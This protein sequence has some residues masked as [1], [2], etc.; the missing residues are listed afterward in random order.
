[1][2]NAVITRPKAIE[3]G[4][5]RYFTGEPCPHG[6][7]VERYTSNYKCVTCA[8]EHAKLPRSKAQMKARHKKLKH[9]MWAKQKKYMQENPEYREHRLAYM[10]N[11]YRENQEYAYAKSREYVI[12][13]RA[14]DNQ[15]KKN[16]AE[17]NKDHVAANWKRRSAYIR[18]ATPSWSDFSRIKKFYAERIRLTE[19]TGQDYHVDHYYPIVS[20]VVCGL[21]VPENLQVITAVE[22]LAKSNKMPEE[23]YGIG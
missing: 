2:E 20:D 17:R 15:Y 21:H 5:P 6:H 22:N 18:R 7:T 1:M 4:L 11:W 3:K 23:F 16:W 9:E 13:N 10:R 19:E 14:R 12:K 8:S